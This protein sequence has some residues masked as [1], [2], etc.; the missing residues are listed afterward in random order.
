VAPVKLSMHMQP[1]MI[2]CL[3]AQEVERDDRKIGNACIPKA[4]G[5]GPFAR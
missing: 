5:T 1:I 4:N 3:K 2:F